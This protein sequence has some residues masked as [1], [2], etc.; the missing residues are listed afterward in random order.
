MSA[1][2]VAVAA[3]IVLERRV[4]RA[5]FPACYDGA[6]GPRAVRGRVALALL[7]AAFAAR[8]A[9]AQD[10]TPAAGTTIVPQQGHPLV[11]AWIADVAG[12]SPSLIAFSADGVV[13]D[14]ETGGGAGV[15]TWQPTGERTA[16]FT[17]LI[18]VGGPGFAATVQVNATVSVDASGDA[19]AGEYSLTVVGADGAVLA[20]ETGT[21]A[22]T[23]IP[24]QSLEAAGTPLPNLPTWT[25]DQE[26]GEGP[27]A[28]PAA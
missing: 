22:I 11:G 10:A 20:T 25:P 6:P 9:L 16:A 12:E 17:M 8:A 7:L 27:A 21:V 23:R 18:A 24:V 15:G 2:A 1:P 19:G 5:A 26:G 14:V 13:T 4:R 28:T 3:V